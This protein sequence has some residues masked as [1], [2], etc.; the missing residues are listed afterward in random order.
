MK[1]TEGNPTMTEA[2]RKLV[3]EQARTSRAKGALVDP[4]EKL[5]LLRTGL[6]WED[7]LG[8]RAAAKR[9]AAQLGGMQDSSEEA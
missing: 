1:A 7:I 5:S 2:A 4:D 3:E 9:N 6:S 8:A